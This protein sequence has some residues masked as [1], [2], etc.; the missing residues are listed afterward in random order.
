MLLV[1]LGYA[2]GLGLPVGFAAGRIGVRD[3]PLQLTDRRQVFVDLAAITGAQ[4]GA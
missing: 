4:P 3:A 1:A 2:V